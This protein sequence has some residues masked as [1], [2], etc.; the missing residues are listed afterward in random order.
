MATIWEETKVQGSKMKGRP[1]KEKLAYFWEYYKIQTMIAVGVIV[2]AAS[3]IHSWVTYK[4]YALCIVEVN[5]I[6]DSIG[7][8]TETWKYDL[9]ELLDF[10]TDDYEID[11]DTSLM[12]GSDTSSA[13]AEYA[14]AQKMAAL[15]SSKSIDI[16][17]ADT[18]VFE[19]YAQNGSFSDLRDIYSYEELS[20]M[21]GRIYY[22][23]AG[24]F[25]DYDETDLN[26]TEK[27]AGYTIDHHDPSTMKDPIPVGFFAD[28]NTRIGASGIYGHLSES[29]TY[30]GYR[31][32]PI[33]G[34]PANTTRLE[35]ALTG[36]EYL[37]NQ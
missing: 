15:L 4:D 19:Q 33:I 5:S 7:G 36:L 8:V 10:D 14:S 27:Q 21:E 37:M 12:L 26:V 32:E 31:T 35:A 22:T 24:T 2:I 3:L 30:Q 34:I 6:A 29:D 13:N 18:P 1:L 25:S 28:E 9:T 17:I 16:F 20:A 11:I 23:D